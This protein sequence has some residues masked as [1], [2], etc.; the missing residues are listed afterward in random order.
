[1]HTRSGLSENLQPGKKKFFK[2]SDYS[3][4]KICLVVDDKLN[5]MKNAVFDNT[6]VRVN[7][8]SDDFG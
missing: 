8:A 3:D 4:L 2:S 6:D 7:K 1:M 5:P